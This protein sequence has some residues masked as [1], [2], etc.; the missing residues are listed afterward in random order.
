M[1][2]LKLKG[3]KKTENPE[4]VAFIFL[5]TIKS[6]LE[7]PY[8]V[9]PD[10]SWEMGLTCFALSSEPKIV[11]FQV[12]VCGLRIIVPLLYS[13]FIERELSQAEIDFTVE[14]Q[15]T[16]ESKESFC[17]WFRRTHTAHPR[18][19]IRE[20]SVDFVHRE[21]KNRL[22]PAPLDIGQDQPH[23]DPEPDPPATE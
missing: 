6:P 5:V 20:D 16:F 14:D 11:E 7:A 4:A 15:R 21:I 9:H 19:L 17:T 8:V 3:L 2:F 23:T 12:F 10:Y 1:R 18:V 13:S 22:C